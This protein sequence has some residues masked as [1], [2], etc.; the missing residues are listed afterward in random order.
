M[1]GSVAVHRAFVARGT[2]QNLL[3][4]GCFFVF[5]YLASIILARGLGPAEYGVYGL[6]MSVLLW[7][8]QIGKFMI[9]PAAAILIPREGHNSTDLERTALFLNFA[10][11]IILFVLLWFAAPVLADL[12]DLHDGAYL[13]RI[14]ALDLPFFG[15]YVVY[16][17][18]LQGHQQ[19]LSISIA[20]FLYSFAKLV[21]TAMLLVLWLS[22]PGALIMNVLA[23]IGALLFALSRIS[24]KLRPPAWN[25]IR[26]LI[27]LALPL[28]FYMLGLQTIGSLDLWCLKVL[29]PSNEAS[30]IGIYVAARNVALVPGVILMVISDVLLPSLS[31]ALA[32][33]D[34]S[35]SR[36]YIQS[37]VR[38]L[39][40]V[41]VPILLL[42]MLVADA[43][44]A[45][46]YSTT[47]SG[48]GIYL[49]MLIFYAMSLPFVD[50][51][52]SALNAHGRPYL[53]GAALFL[54]IPVA[55]P[56]NIIFIFSF[57]A[58]GAAYASALTGVLG[59]VALGFLVYRRF[60]SIIR[61]RTFLNIVVAI[62]LMTAVTN[63]FT[64]TG[65]LLAIFCLGSLVIYGIGLVLMKEITW[66][67]V[68]PFA[69]WRWR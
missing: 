19:F 46:L 12:F 23:S 4:R 41:V 38:F 37:G 69:F 8:E 62:L 42:F 56:L 34:I 21:G 22:V 20:E 26:P 5:G 57:G 3:S 9:P 68:E 14:A 32:Q 64:V 54:L 67:D 50:L 58:V 31:R 55:L 53:S 7:V 18:V 43:I 49:K 29:N 15:M 17:G 61:V 2:A 39:C 59:A 11:F 1:D 65:P 24:I 48:G 10:L 60:G 16:R 27:Y 66:Q 44:M 35:L 13:F 45:L 30:T 40:I 28:G 52:A 51:F 47:F 63:Q 36:H 6:I 25:F 33:N